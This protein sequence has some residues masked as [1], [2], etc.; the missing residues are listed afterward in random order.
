MFKPAELDRI[1]PR[2][3]TKAAT[4]GRGLEGD[5]PENGKPQT[6]AAAMTDD[7]IAATESIA[8]DFLA[9]GGKYSRPFITLAVYDALTGGKATT[10]DGAEHVAQF[11][12][13]IRRAAMSIETFHKA[14]LV[15]DDIEDDDAFRYG[16]ETVH[17]KYGA[18][19]AINVG[20]YLIG[21]GY[22]LVSRESKTLGPDVVAD[23]LDRLADAHLR[24][25]E[26]QGAELIWRD[27]REKRLTPLDA[28]KIYALKTAPAFEAALYSGA[29]LAGGTEQYAEPIK[30][31]ARNLGIAFQIL[32]DLNDWDGDDH[33]KLAAGGDVLGGRPTLLLALALEGLPAEQQNELLGLLNGNEHGRSV[34][35]LARVRNLYHQAD[36]FDKASR[37]IDKHRE[38]AEKIADEIQPE[39]LR[40]LLYYLIDSVL[41]H[42]TAPQPVAL[43]A[44][45]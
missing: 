8:Y 38:R 45:Q 15:H 20:D 17:K 24:L 19:T 31:F 21:M 32:N 2:Q 29:R 40:A 4:S 6:M 25:S 22:R 34:D 39:E 7:P 5:Q 37:L 16:E 26:G 3:R 36:V 43:T 33:N 27:S 10:G 28:L 18:A 41:D 1:A 42:P 14:S 23:I 44:I 9:K 12:D 30:Q 11:S 13:P 35:R